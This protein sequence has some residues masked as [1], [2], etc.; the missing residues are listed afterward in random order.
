LLGSIV[1][2]VGISLLG[3]VM[4]LSGESARRF[5]EKPPRTILPFSL[6]EVD[7]FFHWELLEKPQLEDMVPAEGTIGACAVPA[8]ISLEQ[9]DMVEGRCS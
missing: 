2:G 4:L 7:A 5:E 3:V 6:I 8:A 9:A 1:L